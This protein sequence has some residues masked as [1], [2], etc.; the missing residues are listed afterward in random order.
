MGSAVTY[1]DY[2]HD[3]LGIEKKADAPQF[4][5]TFK[6]LALVTEH[7]DRFFPSHRLYERVVTIKEVSKD[8]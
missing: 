7:R 6:T 8:G 5:D 4:P 1:T 3:I 2:F